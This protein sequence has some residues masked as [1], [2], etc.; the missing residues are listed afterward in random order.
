VLDNGVVESFGKS[1]A[2]PRRLTPASFTA[3]FAGR[4]G[5]KQVLACGGLVDEPTAE[6]DEGNFARVVGLLRDAADRRTAVVVATHEPDV[7]D[8]C[9]RVV[10]LTDG[11]PTTTAPDPVA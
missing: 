7:V 10:H 6:L 4:A 2:R 5:G 11:R 9:D 3:G 1:G 8:L